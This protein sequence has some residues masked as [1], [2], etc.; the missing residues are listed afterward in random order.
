MKGARAYAELFGT[1]Q[2]GRLYFLSGEHA[3]GKTFQ[4]W[5]LPKGIIAKTHPCNI[6]DAVNVYGIIGG[7]PGWSEYYGWLHKGKW[8]EDFAELVEMKLK[9]VRANKERGELEEAS[10]REKEAQRIKAL[11]EAYTDEDENN[12]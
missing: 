9:E 10:K 5:V 8:Q 1:G 6:K 4:I 7:Q 3:R 2:Y 11:L 12:S